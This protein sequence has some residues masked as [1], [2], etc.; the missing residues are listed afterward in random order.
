MFCAFE[1]F[2]YD[3]RTFPESL[4]AKSKTACSIAV[5]IKLAWI[6]FEGVQ[7]P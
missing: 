7:A 6:D 4:Y 3:D 2:L 5:P 1:V